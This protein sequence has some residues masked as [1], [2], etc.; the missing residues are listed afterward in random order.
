MKPIQEPHAATETITAQEELR[1]TTSSLI[2]QEGETKLLKMG[3]GHK[4]IGHKGISHWSCPT[5][6]SAATEGN[7]WHKGAE[8]EATE[9]NKKIL[10]LVTIDVKLRVTSEKIKG[11]GLRHKTKPEENKPSYFYWIYLFPLLV[12]CCQRFNLELIVFVALSQEAVM[13]LMQIKK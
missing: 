5:K 8:F 3:Q 4:G 10:Q 2:V 11:T 6:G 13:H 9:G 12:L 1:N 7:C